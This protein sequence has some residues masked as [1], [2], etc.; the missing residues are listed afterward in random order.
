M[1]IM[2]CAICQN[3][4][5]CKLIKRKNVVCDKCFKD[6]CV[7]K[8]YASKTGKPL[9]SIKGYRSSH[10]NIFHIKYEKDHVI[11]IFEQ[12]KMMHL[13]SHQSDRYGD[14]TEEERLNVMTIL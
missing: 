2:E 14:E 1:E 13:E 10:P 7:T 12:S 3:I 4:V 8:S 9:S 6:K 11:D 5:F